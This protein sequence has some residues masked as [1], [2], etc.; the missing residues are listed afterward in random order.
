[1]DFGDYV[2]IARKWWWVSVSVVAVFVAAAFAYTSAQTPVY[3][4]EAV[5]LVNNAQNPGL[6]SYQDILGS[7]QLTKTYA[8]LATSDINLRAAVEQIAEPGLTVEKLDEKITATGLRDTQLIQISAEDTDPEKA[9]RFANVVAELFPS[10]IEQAQLAGG[11]G[12]A[13]TVAG[14]NTV[15]VAKAARVPE[16]PVRPSTTVNVTLGLL[17]GL[18]IAAAAVAALEYR[19]DKIAAREDVTALSVPVLGQISLADRPK[20]SKAEWVPSILLSQEDRSLVESCRQVQAGLSFALGAAEAKV[21]LITSSNPGEGKSTTSANIALSLSETGRRVLL[22]DADLRK[23][24]VHR[25]FDMPTGSG[26][27]TCFVTDRE[28]IPGFLKQV[29]QTLWVMTAGQVPP[30][31]AELIGSR[32]MGAIVEQ[33]KRPFDVVIIDS[34]PVLGL[35]DASLLMSTA[36]AVVLVARR[37]RTRRKHLQEATATV[38]Q[39]GKPLLGVVLNGSQRRTAAGYYGYGY[40][41]ARR[42]AETTS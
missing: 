36:D 8:Q 13:E 34:P 7:Q 6:A 9:A 14:L 18:L 15:Y 37:G 31:P 21:L 17:L 22:I 27:S 32:K 41:D 40:G 42:S 25:Y 19:D 28:A 12:N 4:A 23:P 38:Q 29:T 33:L 11:S 2:R 24:D 16:S 5:I 30:N 26:L 3:R 20:K 10:S 39:S 1:M 35:A